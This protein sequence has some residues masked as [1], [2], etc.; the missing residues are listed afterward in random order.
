MT[1]VLVVNAGSSSLKLRVLGPDDAV[2]T[3]LDL[4]PWDG[5][6]DD[7]ALRRFL[8]GLGGP[9]A[10]GSVGVV[11]HRVVH[12]GNRFAAS[13]LVD[14]GVLAALGDL[15][16]LAPLHQPRRWPGSRPPG[17]CCPRCRAWPA[18]TP[19]STRG[20]PRPRPPTRC[21]CPGRG[22]LACGGLASTA[23]PTP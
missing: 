11:G 15:T 14:D 10:L 2:T 8:R 7:P 16:D 21:R 5:S 19:R 4:S 23:C 9:G 13:V 3:A 20:C 22:V 6:P 1:S 12:G 17:P 18:S